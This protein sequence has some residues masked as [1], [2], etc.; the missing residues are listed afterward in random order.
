[1]ELSPDFIR[2]NHLQASRNGVIGLSWSYPRF[3]LMFPNNLEDAIRVI[4]LFGVWTVF[5]AL[6]EA[7]SSFP[8]VGS[9]LQDDAS[10]GV[11]ERKMCSRSRL[12]DTSSW[13]KHGY[14]KIMFAEKVCT[15]REGLKGFWCMGWC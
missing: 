1:M 11:V 12:R 7:A 15:V 6:A 2:N 14:C 3:H 8:T 4:A 10:H 5:Q 9:S 13:H